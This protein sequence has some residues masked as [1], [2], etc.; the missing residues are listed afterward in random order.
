MA[1]FDA[2]LFREPRDALGFV[3]AVLE[4]STEYSII[5]KSPDGVIVLWNEGARRNY[6]WEPAEVVGRMRGDVL[7]QPADVRDGLP[8][9]MRDGALRSGKWEGVVTRRRKDG[10]T[11]PARVVMTPTRSAAGDLAGFLLISK[12]ITDEIRL[13]E[14]LASSLHRAEETIRGLSTP[15]LLLAPGLLLVPLV[16]SLDS[17]RTERLMPVLLESIRERRARAIV[18]DVT[19]VPSIDT[20]AA[21][22]LLQ[23]ASACRLMGARTVMSGIP[24]DIASALADL[25]VDMTGVLVAGDLQSGLSQA[26]QLLATAPEPAG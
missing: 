8:A 14:L 26:R 2:A 1:L 6:G 15:V 18:I 25:E 10:S 5:C 23:T 16:G 22:R 3:Q 17:S 7:H 11:F 19:G 20:G 21:T 12:D 4:S 24:I 9:R 13:S